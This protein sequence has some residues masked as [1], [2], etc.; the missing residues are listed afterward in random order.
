MTRLDMQASAD[1]GEVSAYEVKTFK[2]MAKDS[3]KTYHRM[4]KQVQARRS[5][6]ETIRHQYN[7]FSAQ[8]HNA[9]DACDI[10]AGIVTN[11][12][13]V[14]KEARNKQNS[15]QDEY[16]LTER[17]F[18]MHS[19][20]YR[21]S[22][23]RAQQEMEMLQIAKEEKRQAKKRYWGLFDM[24]SKYNSLSEKLTTEIEML[25]KRHEKQT[26]ESQMLLAKIE[27][28]TETMKIMQQKRHGAKAAATTFLQDSEKQG[29][30]DS[31]TKISEEIS[32]VTATDPETSTA[33]DAATADHDHAEP[34]STLA[35]S[36]ASV[37]IDDPLP[38]AGSA[39][40]DPSK[41]A[42]YDTLYEKF[43]SSY[44]SNV[45]EADKLASQS[46]A[47]LGDQGYT[48]CQYYT[49]LLGMYTDLSNQNLEYKD[50][51]ENKEDM[52]EPA[53]LKHA[54]MLQQQSSLNDARAATFKAKTAKACRSGQHQER[55]RDEDRLREQ[56]FLGRKSA[57]SFLQMS[58][59]EAIRAADDQL[60]I[61]H[62]LQEPGDNLDGNMKAM[63]E[64][65][66]SKQ[67]ALA[68]AS[69]DAVHAAGLAIHKLSQFL[70][71]GRE[72]EAEAASAAIDASNRRHALKRKVR[73]YTQY[74]KEASVARLTPCSEEP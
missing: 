36:P 28:S 42:L 15:V 50:W 24:E 45:E 58:A 70:E 59:A 34:I 63:Q 19:M 48:S 73:D 7:H 35:M 60:V 10:I 53:Q 21:E 12:T 51:I 4:L 27:G 71:V 31:G 52:S 64:Q 23:A 57:L 39:S 18:V 44:R 40:N 41:Q 16:D 33:S 2:A 72:A 5:R 43:L 14:Y 68:T 37:A 74:A 49:K 55:A 11:V 32:E 69:K 1:E 13:E 38:T 54:L 26:L 29:C 25:T 9:S 20:A 17:S 46:K 8:Y 30:Y 66:C 3:L 47:L 65:Y 22:L 61:S 62:A 67:E 6:A 56:A